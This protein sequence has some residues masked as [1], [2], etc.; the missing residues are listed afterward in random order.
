[1]DVGVFLLIT[2]GLKSYDIKKWSRL[3]VNTG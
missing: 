2:F 3:R 1:M